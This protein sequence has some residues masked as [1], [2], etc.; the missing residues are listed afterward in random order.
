MIFW[1]LFFSFFKI[2]MFTIGGGYAML[3]LIQQEIIRHGWMTPEEFVDV[4]GIAEI[5]PGPIAINS[6]TFVGFRTA[7]IVGALLSSLAVVLPSVICVSIVT[8]VWERYKQARLV[9]N[10][11]AGLRPVVAGLVAAAAV[12]IALATFRYVEGYL[13][14][15]WTALIAGATFYVVAF[16]KWD[17]IKVLVGAAVL[18]LLI[19]R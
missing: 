1:K 11:F 10:M 19:F 8:R 2:G 18:G 14:Q 15:L 7:G 5:T 17:P 6:A 4:V 9:Q 3:A 16:R 12:L 13:S